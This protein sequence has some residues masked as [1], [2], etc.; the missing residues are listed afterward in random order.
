M[1]TTRRE[2]L[3]A[4][5]ATGLAAAAAS[6]PAVRAFAAPM[7]EYQHPMN[8]ASLTPLEKVHWP[9]LEIS[10]RS[11]DNFNLMIQIGQ[12]IHPMTDGHHIEWVEVWAENK[13][14]ER[15]E[16]AGPTGAK[17]VL[18]VALVAKPGTMLNVRL[19]CN[20]HGLW[21]NSIKA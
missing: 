11:G 21:E 20:L 2:F 1:A 19:S 13:K 7:G 17:P 3:Q 9:K 6:I 16:F 14:V 18:N 10:G 8:P 12:E 15:V 5:V 4:G